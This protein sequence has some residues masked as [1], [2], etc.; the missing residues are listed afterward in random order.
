MHH[1]CEVLSSNFLTLQTSPLWAT[2]TDMG[3]GSQSAPSS[4]VLLSKNQVAAQATAGWTNQDNSWSVLARRRALVPVI[5]QGF[6]GAT[7]AVT[8]LHNAQSL[9]NLGGSCMFGRRNMENLLSTI[10]LP[11]PP[12][13]FCNTTH[14]YTPPILQ[15]C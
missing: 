4:H 13:L 5:R 9:S 7:Q 12:K 15:V 3:T 2:R 10:L 11:P 1:G 6:E 14:V 8:L